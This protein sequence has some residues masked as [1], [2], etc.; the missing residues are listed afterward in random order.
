MATIVCPHCGAPVRLRQFF[1]IGGKPFCARCGWNLGRALATVEAKSSLVTLLP[2]GVVTLGAFIIF[3]GGRCKGPGNALLYVP[4]L[5]LPL[6]TVVPV[7]NRYAT[8]KAIAAAKLTVNPDFALAQPLLDPALQLLQ[9]QP[10]PRR[11]SLRFQSALL[12]PLAALAAVGA[13]AF[14]SM[15][16]ASAASPR[17]HGNFVPFIAFMGV[18][19]AV[20]FVIP[21]VREKRNLPLLRDGELAFARVVSQTTVRQG[22]ASYSSIDYEFQTNDGVRIRGTARDLT[23]S[24]F[25]DMT[26][27]V[28]YDPTNPDRSTTPCAS[29]LKVSTN[30]I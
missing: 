23:N 2:F 13:I 16:G 26:I 11:I 3:V 1:N 17:N 20:A 18:F 7:I 19:L 6:I 15:H 22:K 30:P 21:M 25:E 9:S 5:L 29:Y 4:L 24:V 14:A 27:P 12:V 10:R 28:F 8:K